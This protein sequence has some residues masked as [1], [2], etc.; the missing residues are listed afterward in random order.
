VPTFI[1]NASHVTLTA[2]FTLSAV[3][4]SA[5]YAQD[6]AGR[7]ELKRADLTG[8]NMEVIVSISETKPGETLPRHF[9]N[10]EEAF[11]ALDDATIELPDGKQ[12][13]FKAGTANITVRDVPHG[14]VK[15]VGDK[16]LRLLTVHVV[17]KGKP[18][19]DTPK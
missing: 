18:L 3:L 17:D 19:Y 15:V 13:A 11:Y 10:G 7:K 8:T 16:P 9:H 5:A 4:M 14:G 1:T 12:T 2:V 6:Y